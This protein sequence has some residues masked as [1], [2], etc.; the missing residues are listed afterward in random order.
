MLAVLI[1]YPT[2]IAERVED[3][4]S[5]ALVSA[6]IAIAYIIV[7]KV[8]AKEVEIF[9]EKEEKRQLEIDNKNQKSRLEVQDVYYRYAYEDDITGLKNRRAFEEMKL[10]KPQEQTICMTLDIN[11][12]KE[13]N[14]QHGHHEGDLALK[15]LAR[16]LRR[17]FMDHDDIYRTGGDEFVVIL[18]DY[19]MSDLK[20]L[21]KELNQE[22]EHCCKEHNCDVSVAIGC[23][24]YENDQVETLEDLIRLA[25]KRMYQD[26]AR[27]KLS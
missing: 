23:S 25:D 15:I 21:I 5:I 16:A 2:S 22:L 3:L 20:S 8:F 27:Y 24:S 17:T 6:F 18:N 10:E 19:K 4:P 7:Y 1:S 26:K 14:D 12:L 11:N 9:N 13:L